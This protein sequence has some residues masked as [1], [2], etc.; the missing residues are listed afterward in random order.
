[1]PTSSAGMRWRRISPGRL[2]PGVRCEGPS[3]KFPE[4]VELQ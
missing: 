4:R 3:L 2:F 1:M